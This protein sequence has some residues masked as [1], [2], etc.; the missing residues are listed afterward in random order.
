MG[1]T[2]EQVRSSTIEL[3]PEPVQKVFARLDNISLGGE[4]SLLELLLGVCSLLLAL[5]VRSFLLRLVKRFLRPVVEKTETEYDDRVVN[6]LRRAVSIFVL[7]GGVFLVFTFIQLPK[8]GEVDLQ[9]GVWR[10]LHTAIILSA[11]L[12]A[13]R[14]IEIALHYMTHSRKEGQPS[15]L[16]K[17]FFP[18]MRD[19]AKV[20]VIVF[21]VVAVIQG[22]GYSASGILAGVGIGGLA[23]A[24]A[25]QDTVA[26]IFGSFVIYSDRP[27]KV[28]DW[29]KI[30]GTEGTVEEIGIRSTRIRCFDKTM[31]LI[32][33]K[34]VTNE[35]I[36]NFSEMPVRRIKLYVGLTYETS[37]GD[38]QSAVER[39]RE[40]LRTHPGIDQA[41]WLVNF[42][43]MGAYSLDVMIYCFT[44]TTIWGEY[45][46]IRQ[47][48]LLKILDMCDEMGIEIAFPSS[49]IYYKAAT[50]NSESSLPVDLRPG[51][52]LPREMQS[53]RSGAVPQQGG[54]KRGAEL[55]SAEGD[56]EG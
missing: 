27:Y 51:S 1:T 49:T 41:F 37:T 36:Q 32:P 44:K 45:L 52:D 2:A 16:E 29:I 9:A 33:N 6:A 24:F 28:G 35:S 23:L 31:V 43:E 8:V 56:D 50:G 40:L 20:L 14:I 54:S 18:L 25:A 7:L 11:G 5:I 26:N 21:V 22:W 15:V 3:V 34:Q 46:D 13:Y 12:L 38:I 48:I 42:T 39:I 4:V 10:V 47:E 17:Q 55:D 19:I 30:G 53:G